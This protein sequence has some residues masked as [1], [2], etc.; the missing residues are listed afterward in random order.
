MHE[1]FWSNIQPLSSSI[2]VKHLIVNKTTIFYFHFSIEAIFSG[3][4]NV[5]NIFHCEK[6]W[7]M[8]NFHFYKKCRRVKFIFESGRSTNTQTF[9]KK[10]YLLPTSLLC[11]LVPLNDLLETFSD[12]F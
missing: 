1:S 7:P 9:F 5:T 12:K 8:F 4:K 11:I 3:K 10:T 2:A 6:K